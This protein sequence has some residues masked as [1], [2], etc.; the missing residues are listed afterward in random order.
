MLVGERHAANETAGG[1]RVVALGGPDR[2]AGGGRARPSPAQL[3][4]LARPYVEGTVVLG[5]AEAGTQHAGYAGL[6]C[7]H[8]TARGRWAA[9][10][11]EPALQRSLLDALDRYRVLAVHRAGPL[12]VEGLEAALAERVRAALLPTRGDRATGA[13]LAS[14]GAHWLG[15]PVLVTENA[16]DVGL[17]NGDVGL[18]LPH[19]TVDDLFAAFP[20]VDGSGGVRHVPLSRLPPHEG[21]LAMTVHKAQGSQYDRVALVL[22]GRESAI[23]TRELVYTAV[24]RAKDQLTWL[25]DRAELELALGRRVTR[26]SGLAELLR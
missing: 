4:A 13:R 20:S 9:S 23:Q 19:P 14:R 1:S 15:R 26:A 25:G 5:G 3:D 18:V 2:P 10:L 7:A 24:T 12:G 17:M 8:V 16:Y 21:A 22:A 6:L 11:R